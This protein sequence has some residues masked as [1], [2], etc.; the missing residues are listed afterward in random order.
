MFE[1]W[2]SSLLKAAM[3]ELPEERGYL[4]A[5][6]IKGTS[7]TDLR[8]CFR[9]RN[10][11]TAR[12]LSVYWLQISLTITVMHRCIFLPQCAY[13]WTWKNDG[14]FPH[15]CSP[16][17]SFWTIVTSIGVWMMCNSFSL[18]IDGISLS[19]GSLL[20][21]TYWDFSC[22]YCTPHFRLTTDGSLPSSV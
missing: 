15:L 19:P 7:P 17:K 9:W 21:L 20:Y 22:F 8:L 12:S 5:R 14:P 2:P 1:L 18:L 6:F 11:V 16:F 3:D 4:P 13:A 10:V